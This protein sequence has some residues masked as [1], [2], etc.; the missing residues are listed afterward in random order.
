MRENSFK[1]C[2]RQG[3]NLQNIQTSHTTQQK[4]QPEKWAEDLNS[5]FSKEDIQMVNKHMKKCSTS[6]IIREMQI[7]TTMS[8]H[9]TLVRMAIINKYTN[10]KCWRGCGEKGTLLHCWWERKLVQP[11][12][13]T[14]WRYLRKLNIELPYVSAIPVLGIYSDKTF[15]QKDRGTPMFTAAL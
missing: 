2:N 13:K 12:W 9:F 11:L 1:Q 3:L 7:K 4:K 10:N 14:V 5:Y 15:I 6:S 8:Y